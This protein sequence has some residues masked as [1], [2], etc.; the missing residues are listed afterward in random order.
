[1]AEKDMNSC[2]TAVSM[3]HHLLELDDA[4]VK[5]LLQEEASLVG[6]A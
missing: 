1:M 4:G 6:D 3:L 2:L 5:T